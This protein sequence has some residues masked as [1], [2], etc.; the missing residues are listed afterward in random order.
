MHDA[1]IRACVIYHQSG[2]VAM[3][4]VDVMTSNVITV[5]ENAS[6]QAVAKALVEHGISA[7][8]VVGED[9]RLIGMVSEGDLLHRPET[10]TEQWR[11]WWL[12]MMATR[13]Q[14][15]TEYIKSHSDKVTDVMT[16]DVISVTE[17]TSVSDIAI[18]LEARRI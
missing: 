5:D 1:V 14:L 4:A 15:A 18:L 13:R 8:P 16:H 6:V 12:E 2:A 7:V 3:R 11:A 9:N 10:G 17:E